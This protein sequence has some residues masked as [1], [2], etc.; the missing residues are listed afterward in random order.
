MQV[1]CQTT[2]TDPCHGKLKQ[3]FKVY[4][5]RTNLRPPSG[6]EKLEVRQF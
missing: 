4:Q 2:L 3:S 6:Y 5:I 1:R